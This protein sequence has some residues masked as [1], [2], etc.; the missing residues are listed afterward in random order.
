MERR[1]LQSARYLVP[2]SFSLLLGACNL[3]VGT[4]DA[5]QLDVLLGSAL[6]HFCEDAAVDFEQSQ[7]TLADGQPIRVHCEAAGSGDVVDRVVTLAEQLQRGAIA[8]DAP[9]FPTLISV[10]GEIYQSQL[11]Y[12]TN[13]LFPGQN[14]I[15][16]VTDAPLL[17]HSP[18]VFMA[19]EDL[20]TGLK[21]VD[22]LFDA[23]V[24]AET[25]QDLDSN[26]PP[27][28]IHFVHTAPTRSNSG[29]QTLVTQFAAVSGQRPEALMEADVRQ[30]E[31][32]VQ[33]IQNKITRYG[34]STSSL[35]KAMVQNGPFWAS[36]GSFYESSVIAAN[37]QRQP[38]QP[39]YEAIY[40]AATFTSN[41]RAILPGAP[42]VSAEEKEAAEKFIEFLRSP[43]AQR[44][45]T[46]LGLRP[47]VPGVPLGPKFS[48][49][50]GVDPDATYDSYRSPAPEVVEA[51]I[52]SWE[53]VAKKS[54]LVAV[55]IDSSGSM[56]GQKIAAVQ[57]TLKT[58]VENLGAKNQI[59]LI[60]FDSEIRQ[61]VLIDG[62]SE[63]RGRGIRFISGL[64]ADGG[65]RLYDASLVARNWL[66]QNL[67]AD[68]I[69]AVLV[70]TDGEDSG[71]QVSFDRLANELQSSNF[72]SDDRIAFFTVG[73]G[74]EG[75]F[76]ADILEELA[77]LN[78]GYY[79]K[80]DP[81]TIS[82]LMAD[83]QLE[84]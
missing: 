44:I 18:M 82:R 49:Q 53:D 58:Y 77:S 17:A 3:S 46:D 34:K 40:P 50:F 73:Y 54:S 23:L 51:M 75:E 13:Q 38:D 1:G 70:L 33:Q 36:V 45:A 10:D 24:D 26:S 74:K 14:F 20:A 25:H 2:L 16:D 22:N 30:Y 42:W 56:E 11:I 84:F 6:R 68:A 72:S 76:R 15:P 27:L 39:L 21:Q 55:V 66:Q 32:D 7:P 12:R 63:G 60:D 81:S 48:P 19:E 61:P 5:F 4:D 47:G 41:M 37:T 79:S 59:A 29:L 71:S 78:G 31:S 65:T 9:E 8:A 28:T 62:T 35:A 67:R 69:N 80:G 83:L 43:D 57:A 52:R 64:T